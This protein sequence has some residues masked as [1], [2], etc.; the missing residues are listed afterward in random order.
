MSDAD[1]LHKALR[2]CRRS[3]ALLDA[4]L[5]KL[6]SYDADVLAAL[7]SEDADVMPAFYD[8]IGADGKPGVSMQFNAATGFLLGPGNPS[9]GLITLSPDAPFVLTSFAGI[10][11]IPSDES[12][13]PAGASFFNENLPDSVGGTTGIANY[14][15]PAIAAGVRIYDVA[16]SS[17]MSN[18]DVNSPLALVPFEILMGSAVGGYHG[19]AEVPESV[20]QKAASLRVECYLRR[21]PDGT[22]D[23]DA[24]ITSLRL[25]V[26][27]C[28]YKIFGD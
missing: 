13:L 11:E 8:V 28:G 2:S 18:R 3:I 14:P 20:F 4:E 16:S 21:Q 5:A 12:A 15:A 10:V 27:A 6:G 17:E 26:I 19:D 25:H 22:P 7:S 24:G 9:F 1:A 23:E